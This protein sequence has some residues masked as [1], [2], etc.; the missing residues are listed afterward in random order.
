MTQVPSQRQTQYDTIL[1]I[2]LKSKI[3][4]KKQVQEAANLVFDPE[5]NDDAAEL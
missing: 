2:E 4:A 1:A 5:S 3:K